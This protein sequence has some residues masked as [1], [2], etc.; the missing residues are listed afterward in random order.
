RQERKTT[1]DLVQRA[2]DDHP[3]AQ[4]APAPWCLVGRRWH[5]GL[6]ESRPVVVVTHVASPGSACV[7]AVNSATSVAASSWPIPL[8]S[9]GPAAEA[10]VTVTVARPNNRSSGLL[11]VS[12]VWIREIGATRHSR[13]AQPAR[14]YT[15]SAE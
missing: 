9:T 2:N 7:R 12:T 1:D 6:H 5:R 3:C 11:T 14:V 10:V 8:I 4:P 15:A 13:F